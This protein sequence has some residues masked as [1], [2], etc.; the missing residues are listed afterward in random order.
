MISLKNNSVHVEFLG[1][2][3]KQPIIFLED[4][5]STERDLESIIFLKNYFALYYGFIR[6]DS[7]FMQKTYQPVTSLID[8]LTELLHIIPNKSIL[9]TSGYTSVIAMYMAHIEPS[10]L[11]SLIL[12]HPPQYMPVKINNIKGKTKTFLPWLLYNDKMSLGE[13]FY[14]SSFL[15]NFLKIFKIVSQQK[16]DI[17]TNLILGEISDKKDVPSARDIVKYYENYKVIKMDSPTEKLK[18]EK[19]FQKIL[20]TLLKED[21]LI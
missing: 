3:K 18:K 17:K 4:I 11:R 21:S 19:R 7:D 16:Y 10:L 5:F 9:I 8:S 15:R 12:I 2:E 6:I 13:L 20:Y 1:T 14:K